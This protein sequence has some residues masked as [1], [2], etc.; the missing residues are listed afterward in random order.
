[1]Y[2]NIDLLSGEQC[3]AENVL[4]LPFSDDKQLYKEVVRT[5]KQTFVVDIYVFLYALLIKS[6]TKC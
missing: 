1:M 3:Y 5:K 4:L 6:I 2:E